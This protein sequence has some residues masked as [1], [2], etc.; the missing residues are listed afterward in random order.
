M[1]NGFN[2]PGVSV[3]EESLP[4]RLVWMPPARPKRKIFVP[5]LLL[6]LTII[7]TLAVGAHLATAYRDS[8]PPFPE[9]LSMLGPLAE[10]VTNPGILLTGWPFALT[11]LGILG[12]HE[13]GHFFAARRHGIH[14]TYPYFIPFPNLIGT[15][16]A[17]I[18][19]QSPIMDR[20]A[21]F[22]VGVA[23]PLVGFLVALP[24]LAIG[25]L[26][27]KA[28]AV[29]VESAAIEFGNPPLVWLMAKLFRPDVPT[30][31]LFLDP[32]ARAA[33]VGLFATALN[34]LP[35][36]QLDGGHIFYSVNP[37]RHRFLSRL[38]I[39]LLLAAGAFGYFHPDTAW[40]GWLFWGSLLL[41]LGVR[42]PTVMDP[43]RELDARRRQLAYVCLAVFL[44]CFTPIPFYIR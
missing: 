17:F 23:G 9:S 30:G 22:D 2:Q 33:W 12:M 31:Q 15:M 6:I 38:V 35:V 3:S 13:L 36:G 34:L 16:G 40:L 27:S 32:M 29:P 25:I 41:V 20:R 26:N 4:P 7:S 14:A 39:F 1:G 24:A 5:V 8:Q 28:L 11:L 10:A 37:Q 21:L 18:R 42:H 19:I 44:L 43:R